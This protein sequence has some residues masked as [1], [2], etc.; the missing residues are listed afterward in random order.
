M[1]K[2]VDP[3][4][5]KRMKLIVA[6]LQTCEKALSNISSRVMSARQEIKTLIEGPCVKTF[7]GDMSW[8]DFKLEAKKLNIGLQV[9]THEGYILSTRWN[10]FLVLSDQV[11]KEKAE[12]EKR[13]YKGAVENLDLPAPTPPRPVTAAPWYRFPRSG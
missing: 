5:E 13:H 8:T 7:E 1:P 10:D 3:R 2:F 11:V 6:E 9:T 4:I 12:N